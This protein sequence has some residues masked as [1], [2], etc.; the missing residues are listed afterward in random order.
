MVGVV[1]F[2]QAVVQ[3]SDDLARRQLKTFAFDVERRRILCDRTVMWQLLVM[4][5]PIALP[6]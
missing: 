4:R 5:T 2:L 3:R 6:P 1:R